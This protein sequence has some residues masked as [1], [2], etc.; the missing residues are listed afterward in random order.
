MSNEKFNDESKEA[1]SSMASAI[2]DLVRNEKRPVLYP[3]VVIAHITSDVTDL[4]ASR[5]RE[6]EAIQ[7]HYSAQMN[8][9]PH[10]G[11]VLSL[12]TAFELGEHLSSRF[13]VPAKLKFEVLENAPAVQKVVNGLTYSKMHSDVYSEGISSSQKHLNSFV[14]LLDDLKK[15]SGVDYELLTYKQFQEIPFVRK[16]LLG[17]LTRE[18][19]F[20]PII[21]PSENHL[22]VRFPCPECKFTEKQGVNTVVKEIPDKTGLYLESTCPEH[23][24]Y[25]IALTEN[26]KDFVDMNTPLRNVIKEALFIEEAKAKRALDLMVDG[27]DWVHMAEYVVSEGLALL[28][29][30]Y[31]DRP[32]RFFTPIIED[33]SGAK[34]SKSVYVEKGTYGYLPDGFLNLV[35]FKKEYGKKGIDALWEEVNNWVTDPKKVFR[36]YSAEYLL[37]VLRKN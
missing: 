13:R 7:M 25:G 9:H 36:N 22:R 31:R 24:K 4:F 34:F 30:S 37:S 16:T 26:T 27:G 33:W 19:E 5:M 20:I 12:M 6:K 32:A 29:Y 1:K 3:P 14:E 23:G 35:E 2:G 17:I 21:A 18:S 15:R 28:G 11:T 10:L 8:S